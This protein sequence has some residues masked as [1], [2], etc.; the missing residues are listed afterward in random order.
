MILAG[1]IGGT[2]AYLAIFD[3]KNSRLEKI[4]EAR[5]ENRNFSDFKSLLEEFFKGRSEKPEIACLGVAGPI[6]N[7]NC[8]LTNLGWKIEST[9]LKEYFNK[10]EIKQYQF[11][12]FILIL[13]SKKNGSNSI[14]ESNF[15]F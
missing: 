5:F 2:K 12:L 1:D 9:H 15:I 3:D 6:E 11:L 4:C 10:V 7:G 13:A 8:E 14:F